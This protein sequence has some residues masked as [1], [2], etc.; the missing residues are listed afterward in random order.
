MIHHLRVLQLGDSLLTSNY[1]GMLGSKSK[2]KSCHWLLQ[3][4]CIVKM[5]FPIDFDQNIFTE[6]SKTTINVNLKTC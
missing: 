3:P 2:A 1:F 6:T 4:M 5:T